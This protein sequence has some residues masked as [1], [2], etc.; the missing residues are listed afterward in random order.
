MLWSTALPCQSWAMK[1]WCHHFKSFSL[2]KNIWR[3]LE[4][5]LLEMHQAT[6]KPSPNSSTTTTVVSGK[7][8]P[9]FFVCSMTHKTFFQHIFK[10]LFVIVVFVWMANRKSSHERI[11]Q[12]FEPASALRFVQS[13][14]TIF[15][16][17]H[18][19]L[20]PYTLTLIRVSLLCFSTLLSTEALWTFE[21]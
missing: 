14:G 15:C 3:I 19:F 16:L 2:S 6:G 11:E 21:N 1:P 4:P 17:T 5:S 18:E 7:S 13:D 10:H 9:F 8:Y 12:L 20:Y